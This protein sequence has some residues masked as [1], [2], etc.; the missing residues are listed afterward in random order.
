MEEI[1]NTSRKIETVLQT[2]LTYKH[3]KIKVL[4]TIWKFLTSRI[5]RTKSLVH[6]KKYLIL[7]FLSKVWR[8]MWKER[9]KKSFWVL[10]LDSSSNETKL[11]SSA[12]NE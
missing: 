10:Y 7:F 2:K 8:K 11:I 1:V 6:V 12:Q 4:K 5:I 9:E 3:I